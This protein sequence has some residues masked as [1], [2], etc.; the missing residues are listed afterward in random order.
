M[1]QLI[2][3]IIGIYFYFDYKS[4]MRC[5]YHEETS[6]KYMAVRFN[7]G[8]YGEYLT[9]KAIDKISGNKRI[10]VNAYLP[11]GNDTT[12]EVDLIMIHNTGMYCI[13]SKNY[14]GWIFGSEKSRY[15]TQTFKNGQK[16]Q[17]FQSNYAKCKS[18]EIFGGVAWK[19]I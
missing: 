10:L 16:K 12:T 5:Q 9:F 4:Y 6:N 1:F 8:L 14:S 18:Y 7:T 11:K 13:E 19:T 15:W 3:L 17:I 2:L